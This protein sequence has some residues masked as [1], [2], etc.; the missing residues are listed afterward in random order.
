[1]T[2]LVVIKNKFGGAVILPRVSREQG[3]C[4]ANICILANEKVQKI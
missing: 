2:R 1:M 4:N 3:S